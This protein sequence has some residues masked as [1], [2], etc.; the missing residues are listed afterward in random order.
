MRRTLVLLAGCWTGDV[1]PPAPPSTPPPARHHN[2]RHLDV[3]FD[4]VSIAATR[5]WLRSEH[6]THRLT[7]SFEDPDLG[8][9]EV[10]DK[11]RPV[12]SPG[13]PPTAFPAYR[14]IQIP[15]GPRLDPT[16][17]LANSQLGISYLA[18]SNRKIATY[19]PI[20]GSLEW[21]PG[22]RVHLHGRTVHD[23]PAVI[24]D[25]EIDVV[26]CEPVTH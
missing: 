22:P 20:E 9:V 24:F 8:S 15:L 18:A 3:W 12:G 2:Q 21:L 7:I 13:T 23:A 4:G 26:E 14:Q 25:G 11:V 19:A 6:G 5:A 16:L 1:A 10:C 17:E